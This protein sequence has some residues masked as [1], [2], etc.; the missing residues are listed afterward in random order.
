MC[1]GTGNS[2]CVVGTRLRTSAMKSPNHVLKHS[3]HNPRHMLLHC[4]ALAGSKTCPR[5]YQLWALPSGGLVQ[6]PVGPLVRLMAAGKRPVL[7]HHHRHQRPLAR[8]VLQQ[9]A[10]TLM[11]LGLVRGAAAGHLL[12]ATRRKNRSPLS[13]HSTRRPAWAPLPLTAPGW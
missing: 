12:P 10:A 2:G 13:T 6:M 7:H 9:A 4:C 3:T 1:E 11:A 8:K 5:R